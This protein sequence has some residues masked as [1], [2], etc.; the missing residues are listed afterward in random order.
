MAALFDGLKRINTILVDLDR[1]MWTYISMEY[2]KQQIKEGEVGSSAMPHKMNTRS[3]ERISGL[4]VIL[5][6]HLTMAAALSG[7]QWRRSAT[8][9]SS[10]AWLEPLVAGAGTALDR[11]RG[12]RPH[13]RGGVLRPRCAAG[14]GRVGGGAHPVRAAPRAGGDPVG[15]ARRRRR[16][17]DH[18]GG[19]RAV[20][21]V[22]GVRR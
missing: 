2:F 11:G 8:A 3:C 18:G 17:L 16:P 15:G 21:R 6:G 1:D 9:A 12:Q 5:K 14:A 20:A 10:A 4:S 7:D 13:L 22:R 19:V